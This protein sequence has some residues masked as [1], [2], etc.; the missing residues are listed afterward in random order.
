[1]FAAPSAVA[2]SS[3][4][5]ERHE[6]SARNHE[7]G[8]HTQS[9]SRLAEA[10]S[11]AE[12]SDTT[13]ST[14][15]VWQPNRPE[16]SDPLSIRRYRVQLRSEPNS[17]SEVTSPNPSRSILEGRRRTVVLPSELVTKRDQIALSDRARLR[18]LSQFVSQVALAGSATSL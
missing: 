11:D 18:G 4:C 16:G 17:R 6:W 15:R 8:D 7:H 5:P 14:R 2:R 12:L 3:M 10:L 1:M 13:T 9:C